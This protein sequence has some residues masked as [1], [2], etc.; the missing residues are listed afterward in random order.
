MTPRT[1]YRIGA[2]ILLVAILI[3]LVDFLGMTGVI[4]KY[5]LTRSLNTIAIVFVVLSVVL[6]RRARDEMTNPRPR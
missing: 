4:P 2:A 1:R 6:R 5:G 3:L